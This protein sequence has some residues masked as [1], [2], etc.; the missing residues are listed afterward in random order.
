MCGRFTQRPTSE[1]AAIFAAA[2]RLDDASERYNVAPT[3][4]IA[5]VVERPD[6]ERAVVG[7]RWG[8]VPFWTKGKAPSHMFNTRAETVVVRPPFRG[9]LAKHRLIVPAD[10][11]YEWQRGPGA[12]KQPFYIRRADGR[13]LAL[14]GLWTTWHAP[15]APEE[16]APL[17]SATILTTAPN[18]LLGHIH[19]RM[20]VILAEADWDRWLN[21]AV[22]DVADFLP[23]L[24]PAADDLLEAIPVGPLVNSSRNQGPEL[25]EAVGP[26]LIV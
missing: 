3:Q 20:P 15:E 6:S 4:Q 14:A 19:D 18:G 17:R 24:Q 16:A 22:T 13:P 5:V 2:D 25:V 26:A 10:G 8:L 12:A 23:L 7:Y 11:F 9:L 1:I 21:P